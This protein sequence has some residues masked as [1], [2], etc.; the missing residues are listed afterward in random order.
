MS[1]KLRLPALCA[2]V[3]T[4][5]LAQG[6]A[7]SAQ[8]QVT[9]RWL[10]WWEAEYGK[11]VMD[12]LTSRFKEQTGI[13]VERMSQFFTQFGREWSGIMAL[14]VVAWIPLVAAFIFL[15][16]WVVEGLTAGAVK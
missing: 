8:E 9:L 4:A 7:A 12:T 2:A 10:E 14:N 3:V 13:T 1:S 11:E 6:S 5:L 16:R 15:Q